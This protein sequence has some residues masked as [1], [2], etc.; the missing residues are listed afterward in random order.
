M[1]I[2]NEYIQSKSSV[3]FI[4]NELN[5]ITTIVAYNSCNYFG[6]AS[7]V[8]S[9]IRELEFL[10]LM[11]LPLLLS[12]TT[13]VA[14]PPVLKLVLGVDEDTGAL[15]EDAT[16]LVR[17]ADTMFSPAEIAVLVMMMLGVSPVMGTVA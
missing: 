11:L 13:V 2:K 7:I 12:M 4:V 5:K 15:D 8:V 9:D 3:W 14:I 16:T 1:H 6:D 17:F 10:E